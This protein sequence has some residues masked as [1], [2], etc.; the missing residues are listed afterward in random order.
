MTP[1]VI[2][3]AL[4]ATLP[5]MHGVATVACSMQV[6]KQKERVAHEGRFNAVM[7]RHRQRIYVGLMP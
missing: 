6:R 2:G 7:E 5:T 1:F 4:H 3:S